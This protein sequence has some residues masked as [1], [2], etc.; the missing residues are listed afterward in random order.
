[1]KILKI[2]ALILAAIVS[3]S[4]IGIYASYKILTPHET[5]VIKKKVH[6]GQRFWQP[7]WYQHQKIFDEL[8]YLDESMAKIFPN[9]SE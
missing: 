1:M 3:L 9:M 8:C 2:T 6:Y 5:C 4:S 7:E